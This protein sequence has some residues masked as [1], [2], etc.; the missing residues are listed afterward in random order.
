MAALTTSASVNDTQV[1]IPLMRLSSSRLRYCY[2]L[3][4]CGYQ[5]PEIPA[6]AASLGHVTIVAP[7]PRKG[8]RLVPLE[9][10]RQRHFRARTAVERF[11]S[12]LKDGGTTRQVWVRSQAKVHTTLMC[13][14]LV[15]FFAKLLPTLVDYNRRTAGALTHRPQG[16]R[17]RVQGV[18]TS[19]GRSIA[20]QARTTGR[21]RAETFVGGR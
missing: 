18:G 13:A 9:S 12:Q 20:T 8:V 17:E 1:T 7:K 3:M 21:Q 2:A 10:D 14:L 11:Y 6:V 19:T 16:Q 4:D 15:V 5:G